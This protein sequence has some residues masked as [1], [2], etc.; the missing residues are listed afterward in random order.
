M[1]KLDKKQLKEL[2]QNR[3]QVGGIYKVQCQDQVWYR[4]TT[5]LQSA[6]NKFDFSVNTNVFFEMAMREAWNQYG[7]HSFTFEIIDQIE[8]KE[9]QTAKEFAED[10]DTLFQLWVQKNQNEKD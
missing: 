8:K 1:N 10:I 2:Y 9:T 4:Q 6:K 3:I 5:N 7:G